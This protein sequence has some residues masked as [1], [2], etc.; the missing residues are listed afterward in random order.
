MTRRKEERGSSFNEWRRRQSSAVHNS[1]VQLKAW[2]HSFCVGDALILKPALDSASAGGMRGVRRRGESRGD[3]EGDRESEEGGLRGN[4][5]GEGGRVPREG[6]TNGGRGEG[7]VKTNIF[8]LDNEYKQSK[9]PVLSCTVLFVH[10]WRRPCCALSWQSSS[11]RLGR[12][13]HRK[14]RPCWLCGEN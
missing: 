6:V 8:K 5:L 7:Q 3:R 12:D 13:K 4:V 10:L 11:S 9:C 1:A 2:A 14:M